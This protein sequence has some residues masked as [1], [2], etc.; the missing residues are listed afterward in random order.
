VYWNIPGFH[1]VG[2]ISSQEQ[3]NILQTIKGRKGNWFVHILHMNR[4]LKYVVEGIEVGK[5]R[6]KR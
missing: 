4:L 1:C 3:R 5:T 2:G 6:K